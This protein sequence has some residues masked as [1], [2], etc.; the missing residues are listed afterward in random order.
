M[1]VFNRYNKRSPHVGEPRLWNWNILGRQFQIDFCTK[2]WILSMSAVAIAFWFDLYGCIYAIFTLPIIMFRPK[3]FI[4]TTTDKG[5]MC[6]DIDRREMQW[7]SSV[8]ENDLHTNLW[9]SFHRLTIL[10]LNYAFSLLV[11][12]RLWFGNERCLL[13]KNRN[14]N[15]NNHLHTDIIP[16]RNS[17]RASH[18]DLRRL[19]Q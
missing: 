13:G 5:K 18:S 14:I 9:L 3:L 4:P 6:I 7:G 15:G 8:Y 10:H 17:H 12:K 11:F 1:H 2:L 16:I 19:K